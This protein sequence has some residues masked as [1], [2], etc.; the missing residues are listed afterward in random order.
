LTRIAPLRDVPSVFEVTEKF[1]VPSPD[2]AIPAV[3]TIQGSV[4]AAVQGQPLV[5]VTVIVLVEGAEE[6]M[7]GVGAKSSVQPPT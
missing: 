6:T 1:T 4:S 3:I 5:M 7:M 2:P